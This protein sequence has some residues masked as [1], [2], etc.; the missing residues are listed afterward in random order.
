MPVNTDVTFDT[1]GLLTPGITHTPG[2]ANIVVTTPGD[3]QINFTTVTNEPNQFAV[4]VNGAAVPGSLYG[5]GSGVVQNQGFV[6]VTLAA[7]DVITLRNVSSN[8]VVLATGV[9]GTGANV[10]AS[11]VIK[12]LD[13]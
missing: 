4:F 3:Y 9:G 8:P 13:E 11:I 6:I 10:N 5:S 2:S 1:N 7:N 12:K